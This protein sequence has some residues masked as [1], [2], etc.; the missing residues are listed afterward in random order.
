[1]TV[2]LDDF[3]KLKKQVEAAEKEAERAK[4]AYTQLLSDLKKEFGVKDAKEAKALLDKLEKQEARQSQEYGE[5]KEQFDQTY[6]HLL[7][8]E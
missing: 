7:E 6:R 2:A 4:G 8:D 5:L 3:D 1:M